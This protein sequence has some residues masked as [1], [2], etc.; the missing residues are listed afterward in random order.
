MRNIVIIV[1]CIIALQVK[2]Q[3]LP[4]VAGVT[5]GQSYE[6]CKAEL[7]NRYNGGDSSLQSEKNTLYYYDIM[8]AGEYFSCAIF[9]FQSCEYHSYLYYIN[10]QKGFD[11]DELQLAKKKRD[12][13]LNI[14]KKKYD[15]RWSGLADNGLKYYVLGHAWDNADKGF[16]VIDCDKTKTVSGKMKYWT[17]VYYGPINFI[18]PTSEI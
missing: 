1:I 2:A 7:D 4:S 3:G 11:L 18:D 6:Q 16:I 12:R 14:Y 10:F 15:Y 8:F 13:L 17:N 9:Y 5:F